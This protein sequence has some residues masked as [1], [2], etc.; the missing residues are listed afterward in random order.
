[1]AKVKK[2][3]LKVKNF[4]IFLLIIFVIIMVVYY[5]FSLRIK[6][7][8]IKGNGLLSDGDIILALKIENYPKM[9]KYSKSSFKKNLEK[10]DLVDSCKIKRNILGKLEVEIKEA[11]PLFYDRN[12]EVYVLNNGKTT[13]KYDFTGIPFLINYVPDNIYQRL[14]KELTKIDKE[15]LK[16]VSEIEYNPSKSKDVI[17]DDTRFLLRMNDGNE[18]YI[19]LINIERLNSYHLIYSTL[20]EKGVLELDS[21]NENV[22]FKSYKSINEA[23]DNKNEE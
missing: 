16:L 13:N 19:N 17:I 21:D 11:E 23:K 10:L 14:I 20:N 1:M 4:I 6:N 18:V 12:N 22:V 15:N 9:F 7:I 3:K 5:F 8:Y 2:G